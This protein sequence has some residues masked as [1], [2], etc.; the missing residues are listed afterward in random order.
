MAKVRGFLDPC[1]LALLGLLIP[2]KIQ[3]NI[4]NLPKVPGDTNEYRFSN[5]NSVITAVLCHAQLEIG[6]IYHVM[7]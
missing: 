2:S 3:K 6:I 7:L 5:F 4:T 1:I